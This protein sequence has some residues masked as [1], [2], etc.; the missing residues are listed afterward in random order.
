MSATCLFSRSLSA[1]IFT[2]ALAMVLAAGGT[3]KAEVR[4][5][6]DFES[7][8]VR[9]SGLDAFLYLP[10]MR[11]VDDPLPFEGQYSARMEI[12][13]S[14]LPQGRGGHNRVEVKKNFDESAEEGTETFF[15]WSFMMPAPTQTH[16]DIGY[17]ESANTFRQRVAFFVDPTPDGTASRLGGRINL[18]SGA[19]YFTFEKVLQPGRWYR[20]V[21][22]VIWSTDPTVGRVSVWLNGEQIVTDMAGRTKEDDNHMFVQA[23]LH[24]D[25]QEEPIETIYLDSMISATTFEEVVQSDLVAQAPVIMSVEQNGGCAVVAPASRT[26]ASGLAFVAL[27][28]AAVLARRQR[29]ANGQ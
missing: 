28:G 6:I 17:F 11:V 23:G 14:A 3:A 13:P 27:L 5:A 22:H 18:V 12:T 9:A 29:F 7:G 1:T 20:L 4:W 19:D 10:G 24:R 26:P 16:N 8:D 21:T 15:G 2:A 25:Q